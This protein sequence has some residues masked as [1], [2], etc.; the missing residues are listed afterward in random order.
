MANPYYYASLVMKTNGKNGFVTV[1]SLIKEL[2]GLRE[3]FW[4]FEIVCWL[5]GDITCE[6]VGARPNTDG[7]LCLWI[8]EEADDRGGYDVETLLN[9]LSDYNNN[10]QI[11]LAGE[12]RYLEFDVNRD[13]GVFSEANEDDESVGFYAKVIGEYV[14]GAERKRR[15]DY[16]SHVLNIV[17]VLLFL[18]TTWWLYRNVAALVTHAG[19]Y[20]MENIMWVMVCIVLLIVEVMTFKHSKALDD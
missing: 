6:I 18:F 3:E 11:Y 8:E 2:K 13:G 17:L 20:A 12:G 1:G 10:T 19:M 15:V 7:G 5:P 14:I 9:V 4:G 16:K